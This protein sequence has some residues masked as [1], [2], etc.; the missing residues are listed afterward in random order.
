MHTGNFG[1]R[2]VEAQLP[3]TSDTRYAIG[4]LTKA[5]TAAAVGILV[6]EGRT[7]W[8]ALVHDILG[9]DFSFS[10]PTLTREMSVLDVLSHKMGLQRS[11]Q[12]WYGND[13]ALLLEKSRV[14]PHMQYIKTVQPF[15]STEHYSNWG[16]AL[17]GATIEKLS[18][19]SWGTYVKKSLLA[20]L[21]MGDSDSV[22]S[23]D[24]GN[25]AKPYTVVDDH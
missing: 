2:D 19:D 12:L 6:E 7:A 17:A 14:I 16:Y 8:D 18:R 20:P 24:L 4:S 21:Y 9:D 10:N 11:N 15:K 1:H 23:V 22:K 3:P 13:N 25:F 5:F